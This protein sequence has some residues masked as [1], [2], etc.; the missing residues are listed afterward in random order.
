M[1]GMPP[2]QQQP[3]ARHS[4]IQQQFAPTSLN[5]ISPPHSSQHY[6]LQQPSYPPPQQFGLPPNLPGLGNPFARQKHP[7]QR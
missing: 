2:Q 6:Q 4:G 7:G 3:S 1:N 5:G